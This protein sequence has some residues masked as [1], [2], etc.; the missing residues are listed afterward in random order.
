[1]I[2][3]KAFITASLTDKVL[4]ELKKHMEIVYEPWRDTGIIY[5]DVNEL[6]EKLEGI[7]IFI[8]E[9]D[10]LKKTEL[11][12]KTNLKLLASCRGDP[13]NIDLKAA[14]EKKIPVIN[15]PLRNVDAVA[16]LTIGFMLSLA[17]KLPKV[18]KILHSKDFEV[19][20]FEDW[21]EYLKK[22]QGIEIK[23]K[24]IGII[25]FGQIGRRVA[26][27]L[28]PFE[29]NFIIYDPYISVEKIEEYGKKSELDFLMRNSDFITIHAMATDDNDNLIN[30]DRIKMMKKTAYIINLAKGS[31]I[32]YEA[33]HDALKNKAIAGAAL[34]VFP[35]EPIDEDNE[36]LELNNVIV[37]PHIGGNTLEVIERQSEML[38]ED[39]KAWLNNQT[40]KHCLN[41]EVFTHKKIAKSLINGEIYDLKS[42]IVNTCKNLLKDGHVIGSAG[43]VSVR[44]KDQ[45]K[46]FVLI[47]PSN[48]MYDEMKP[49]DILIIDL[50]GKVIEGERNPSVE[51]HL[52]LGVY[53]A[54]E[55]VNAIIHTHGIYSTIL[56]TLNLSLPPIFEE[57]VP[58]LGG[59]IICAEYGEAGSAEL[60]ENVIKSLDEKNALLLANHGNLCCGS[61]LEGAYIV[62]EYLERGAKIYYMAKLVKEPNLL[63]EE[64]V[65]FEKEI[66]EIFKES[67][68]I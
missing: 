67:K 25:G 43:N 36:F 56:S 14:T 24:T 31:I 53:K 42:K 59:E 60:A 1:M 11:F 3:M 17:R 55:D 37:S 26:D 57:L 20:D 65:E 48:V 64:T 2:I 12:E 62:L 54:R 8:T 47:T 32:N 7:D 38:V 6:A 45:E 52:H 28:K 4:T 29:V 40:P 44:V 46:E 18:E 66:F 63:P 19:V 50:E 51:K 22:F 35:M 61:H 39:I 58:Y 10:D 33:L 15:A 5:F 21:V 49:E 27:R 68:K 41:P 34:D 30:D 13:F 9:A 16:E 23:G